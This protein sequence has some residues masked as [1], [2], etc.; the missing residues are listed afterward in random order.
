MNAPLPVA[1]AAS[2]ATSD[3]LLLG[4]GP[5]DQTHREFLDCV[6]AV[7]QANDSNL[8]KVFTALKS[9]LQA[10]FA[11]EDTWMR[12]TA[13]PAM[14]CH[15]DEHAEV[16]KSVLQVEVLL[17]NGNYVVCYRLARELGKWFPAH[18]TYLDSALSQWMCKCQYG[19]TP[20]VLRRRPLV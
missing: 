5:M 17:A 2:D 9:H 10:H 16:M 6:A 7:T 18:A 4:Y 15:I 11:Q 19:G 8:M 14:E 20:V 12:D 13:F 1:T 3:A